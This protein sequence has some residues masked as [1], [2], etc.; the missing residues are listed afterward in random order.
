MTASFNDHKNIPENEYNR[1]A[2]SCFG[3]QVAIFYIERSMK[4]IRRN[5]LFNS[6]G[7]IPGQ[8][9]VGIPNWIDEAGNAC[10]STPHH[11]AP[12]FNGTK[13]CIRFVLF[14]TRRL[15]PPTIV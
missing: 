11:P 14:V 7:Y 8:L 13:S 6:R 3:D 2:K 4:G 5:G 12:R 10:I 15:S 9:L 1:K